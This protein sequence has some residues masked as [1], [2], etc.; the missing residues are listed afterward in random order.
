MSGIWAQSGLFIKTASS[1]GTPW[2]AQLAFPSLCLEPRPLEEAW[3]N[4]EPPS[5]DEELVESLAADGWCFELEADLFCE[6]LGLPDVLTEPLMEESPP[7]LPN[8]STPVGLAM[9]TA[10]TMAVSILVMTGD[11]SDAAAADGGGGAGITH[12]LLLCLRLPPLS[13][14]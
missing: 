2:S 13:L 7:P 11:P 3:L 4:L 14:V 1:L 6:E 12:S 5:G 10:L 9:G 8:E